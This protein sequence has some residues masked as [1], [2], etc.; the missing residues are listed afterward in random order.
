MKPADAAIFPKY[1]NA[2]VNCPSG[3]T[4][5]TAPASVA[6]HLTTQVSAFSPNFQTPYTEQASATVEY[7]LTRK[8][9]LS[10]SYLYVHGEHLIRSLDANLPKPKVTEYPGIR[11]PVGV[12]GPVLLGGVVRNLANQAFGGLPVSAVPERC[13]AA[14]PETGNHQLFRERGDQHLQR[15]NG[16]AERPDQQAI[17]YSRRDTR[18]P[19]QS[20]MAPIRWLWDGRATCRTRTLRNWSA[21]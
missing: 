7:G 20:M 19:R 13:A 2:L 5:C 16:A 10:A 12:Y 9:N 8:L 14:G 15:R 1:P 4:V 21:G 3:A 17:V 11:R 6:S 18:L